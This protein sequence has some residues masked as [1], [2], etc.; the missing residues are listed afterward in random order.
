[1]RHPHK[2]RGQPSIRLSCQ[3]DKVPPAGDLRHQRLMA[4]ADHGVYAGQRSYFLGARC[5]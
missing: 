4:V 3:R 1:M 2:G 5:A